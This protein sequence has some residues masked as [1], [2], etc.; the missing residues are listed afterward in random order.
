MKKI[1]VFGIFL[2]A[3]LFVSVSL[4]AQP[5]KF[6]TGPDS[7]EC[8]QRLSFYRSYVLSGDLE[9]AV[10]S[11]RT[12][13]ALCPTTASQYLYSDGQRIIKEVLMR[14]SG[15]T[16]QQQAGLI[17]SLM[18]MYDIRVENYP[19]NRIGALQ[20]KISEMGIFWPDAKEA[21]LAEIEKLLSLTGEN[22]PSEMLSVYMGLVV[23]LYGEKKRS[24]EEVMD[25]YSK[26]MSVLET[27]EK[28]KPNDAEIKNNKQIVEDM[29]IGSGVATCDNLILLFAPR[30]EAAPE[31]LDLVTKMV[32]LLGNSDCI[33]SD[34]FMKSVTALNKLSP[35]YKTAFYLY[36]LHYGKGEYNDALRSLQ[37]AINSSEVT[38]EE[39][40]SYQIEEAMLYF[41]YLNSPTRA[42]ASARAA[43]EASSSMR[44]KAYMLMASVWAAQ[45][46]G[47]DDIEKR[48]PFWVAVDYLARA[49]AAD[50]SCAE[51]ADRMMAQYRQYFPLQEEAF[52]YDLMDGAEYSVTCSGLRETTTVRTRK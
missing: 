45:K 29:L 34:L 48:A 47:E 16:A 13:L 21:R 20:N 43:M 30:F 42:V 22:I 3:F 41:R 6:G 9:S 18:L 19:A 7:T 25:S 40:G 36:R 44:G 10:P 17:D 15:I 38:S 12:A 24:A 31:D 23:S 37:E 1:V 27:Q 26:L 33:T 14:Q 11:W 39:K 51:E 32:A 35:S 8:K 5:G 4:S 50:P 2:G 28:A 46:C 49:K 52:M